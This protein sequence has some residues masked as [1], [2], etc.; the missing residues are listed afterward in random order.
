VIKPLTPRQLEIAC[1]ILKGQTS[2]KEISVALGVA[3]QTAKNLK[4]GLFR[5]LGIHSAVEL[6]LKERDGILRIPNWRDYFR[7]KAVGG[8]I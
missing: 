3:L 8:K 5:R 7:E 4:L 1:L 6:I 2:D